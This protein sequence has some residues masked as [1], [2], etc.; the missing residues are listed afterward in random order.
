MKPFADHFSGV[1]ADY[2]SCRPRYPEGLFDYLAGQAPRR[3]LAWDCAAGSGQASIPLAGRF[4][5]VVATD[6]STTMLGRAPVHQRV[7]YR[8]LPAGSSGLAGGSVDLVTVA[9]ALHWLDLDAFY[10]E[11]VRVLVPGGILAAWTYGKQEIDDSALQRRLNNFYGEVVGPY[12]PD[13]RRHVEAGYR[14]LSFPFDELDPPPFAIEEQW[15]LRQLLGYIGTWSATQ[16]FRE[17]QGRD[18]LV[19]LEQELAASWGGP[20]VRWVRWP[21]ALRVGRK[22]GVSPEIEA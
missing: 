18:P 4:D 11:V 2:A 1:A 16:R 5:Q 15:T 6:I 12:W 20:P 13:E 21:L 22:L 9:Q 8:V 3:R 14:T 17:A 19:Q 7:E 10:A